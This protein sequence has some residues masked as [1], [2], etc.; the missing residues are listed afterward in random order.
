[1]CHFDQDQTSPLLG[2]LKSRGYRCR[3]RVLS[4]ASEET[5]TDPRKWRS[6]A[7]AVDQDLLFEGLRQLEE[8]ARLREVSLH[9][10]LHPVVAHCAG[11]PAA[12]SAGHGLNAVQTA[13]VAWALLGQI[14]VD[15]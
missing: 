11:Q 13:A 1:M 12:V 2:F 7:V 6:P 8:P 5:S 4:V 14:V 10:R 3:E 15:R 9:Q